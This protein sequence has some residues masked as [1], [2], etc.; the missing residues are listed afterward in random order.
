MSAGAA[1]LGGLAGGGAALGSAFVSAT[2]SKVI[3]KKARQF[4]ERM[5]NTAYQRSQADLKAAGLNPILAL[6]SPASSPSPAM[7]EPLDTSQ[8]VSSAIQGSRATQE[9]K[10]LKAQENKLN[11]AVDLDRVKTANVKGANIIQNTQIPRARLMQA[12]DEDM[13]QP[14]LEYLRGMFDSSSAKDVKKNP[15]FTI[16]PAKKG[17]IEWFQARGQTP[18]K[19]AVH[20]K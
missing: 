20:A 10:N 5:S 18:P 9:V 7:A 16:S 2:S 1:A 19:G 14:G 3:A 8:V 4:Q 11:S 17:T 6:G 13:L 15:S 12:F